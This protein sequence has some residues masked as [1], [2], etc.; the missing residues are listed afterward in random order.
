MGYYIETPYPTGKAQQLASLH[1]AV[2]VM[3]PKTYA[4]I[5]PDKRLICVVNNGLFDAA[6]LCYS[7][8]EFKEFAACAGDSRPRTWMLM[9]GEKAEELS[10][11]TER[12]DA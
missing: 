12:N 1:G 2:A 8:G 3:R 4:D 7:E 5:P 10:G 6:A 11:Y 9:D